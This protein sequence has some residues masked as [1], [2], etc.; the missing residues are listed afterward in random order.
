[1]YNRDMKTLNERMIEIAKDHGHDADFN[2]SGGIDVFIEYKHLGTG[3]RG[4]ERFPVNS[5][6]QLKIALGY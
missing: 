1:M 4:T 3:K 5:L 6:K 2:T